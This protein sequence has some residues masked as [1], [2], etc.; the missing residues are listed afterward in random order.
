MMKRYSHTLLLLLCFVCCYKTQA[1]DNQKWTAGL[2]TGAVKEFY[3]LAKTKNM[4]D[5]FRN[6]RTGFY[7]QLFI[8]KALG[9]KGK[10]MIE[11]NAGH[12]T[13]S[14]ETYEG[15]YYPVTG[16]DIATYSF[17]KINVFTVQF[18]GRYAFLDMKTLKW[19]H[20]AGI[21]LNMSGN[22]SS[23]YS[24][25]ETQNVTSEIQKHDGHHDWFNFTGLEYFGKIDISKKLSIQYLLDYSLYS[26]KFTF[27]GR[28][29]GE[30]PINHKV[31]FNVG[32][33]LHF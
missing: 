15:Y 17:Q 11:L 30:E 27:W 29:I 21:L 2:R 19:K 13:Y 12:Y 5:K 33:G 22:Y 3:S 10:W 23:G 24:F 31:N 7:N 28:P 1:Q 14:Y 9:S 20:Y 6:I 16:T 26:D 32:L 4:S 18:S 25:S 8:N